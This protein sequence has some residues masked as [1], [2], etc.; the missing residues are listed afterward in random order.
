M[1]SVV[2]FSLSEI[3]EEG[4]RFFH[5]I[6]N[7]V[8]QSKTQNPHLVSW[9][10][11]HK[12]LN[13]LTCLKS[14]HGKVVEPPKTLP[15]NTLYVPY[16]SSGLYVLRQIRHAFCHNGLIYDKASKQYSITL[17][18]RVKIAGKFSLE[19]IKEFVQV[20]LSERNNNQPI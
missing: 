18:D 13:K 12:A 9:K 20:F 11:G 16:F 15:C 7:W 17:T 1:G 6:S 8:E 3:P 19:A 14:K 5:G 2:S 4:L 10:H